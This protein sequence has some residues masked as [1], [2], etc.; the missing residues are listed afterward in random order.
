MTAEV[1]HERGGGA[2]GVEPSVVAGEV[3]ESRPC[4]ASRDSGDTMHG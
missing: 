4:C 2:I 1:V 3:M